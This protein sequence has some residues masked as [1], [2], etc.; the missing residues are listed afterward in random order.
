[1]GSTDQKLILG[2]RGPRVGRMAGGVH[3]IPKALPGPAMPDPSTLCSVGG[4]PPKWPF[5]RFW[6]GLPLGWVACGHLQPP[7]IPHAV[8]A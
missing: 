7:W 1:M 2:S 5:G 4:P 6:G 3:E 8:Q